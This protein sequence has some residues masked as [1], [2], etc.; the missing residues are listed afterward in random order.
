MDLRLYF[1]KRKVEASIKE[2]GDREDEENREEDDS[3]E[4]EILE[5][6]Q[7]TRQE[8]V[9]F[10]T[11]KMEM[12]ETVEIL[13]EEDGD[14]RQVDTVETLEDGNRDEEQDIKVMEERDGASAG[15]R[16]KKVGRVD[17]SKHLVQYH[18]KWES[19]FPWLVPKKDNC[20]A[21]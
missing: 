20:Y 4:I 7:D 14:A 6:D 12:T 3:E 13:E 15:T 2:G 17:S 10:R 21:V 8:I 11:R 19:E 9:E 18:T 5:E 16:K 1:K